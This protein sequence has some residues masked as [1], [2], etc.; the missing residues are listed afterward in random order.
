MKITTVR[1]RGIYWLFIFFLLTCEKI[2]KRLVCACLVKVY[3]SSFGVY[4]D[5]ILQPR[6]LE[7]K[8]TKFLLS[9]P[10]PRFAHGQKSFYYHQKNKTQFLQVLLHHLFVQECARNYFIFLLL[11]TLFF[12]FQFFL[13]NFY[14]QFPQLLK[15]LLMEVFI[16]I[17]FNFFS[18][19]SIT[20][21]SSQ[22]KFCLLSSIFRK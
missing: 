6:S 15:Q 8:S 1:K 14:Q 21:S 10:K 17:L 5:F 19:F 7:R 11:S 20:C 2:I 22:I 12:H 16:F 3:V 18:D 13:N 9:F 4:C